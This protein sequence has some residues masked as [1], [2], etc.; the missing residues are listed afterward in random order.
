MSEMGSV[1][2]F[3]L[4]ARNPSKRPGRC[5]DRGAFPLMT[6]EGWKADGKNYGVLIALEALAPP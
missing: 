5:Q 6:A 1:C 2:E 3:P 4:L